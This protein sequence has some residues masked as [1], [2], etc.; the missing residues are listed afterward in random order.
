MSALYA[1]GELQYSECSNA[2]Q[3]VSK[4]TDKIYHSQ[5]AQKTYFFWTEIKMQS[6][7]FRQDD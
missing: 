6:Y 7:N 5:L 4:S 2:F 3:A 1:S